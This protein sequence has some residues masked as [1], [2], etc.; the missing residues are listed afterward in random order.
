MV[1]GRWEAD[2]NFFTL[3]IF[4][5]V[6]SFVIMH[7]VELYRIFKMGKTPSFEVEFNSES[8]Q[9]DNPLKPIYLVNET[10]YSGPIKV[11]GM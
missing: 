5:I 6:W 3:Y 1:L 11:L 9:V 8:L 10:I 4:F 7:Y 2:F